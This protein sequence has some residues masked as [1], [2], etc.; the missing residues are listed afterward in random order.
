MINVVGDYQ[1]KDYPICI[2][3]AVYQLLQS[4]YELGIVNISW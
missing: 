2:F 4:E 1:L 3:V